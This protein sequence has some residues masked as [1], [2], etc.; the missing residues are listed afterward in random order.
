MSAFENG[1]AVFA[2]GAVFDQVESLPL[3]GGNVI[4][5]LS[6]VDE[7]AAQSMAG[8]SMGP[9]NRSQARVPSSLVKT[10]RE[11]KQDS[12]M[13]EAGQRTQAALAKQEESKE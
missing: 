3:A 8:L 10:R 4:G 2:D 6:D 5:N 9:P 7:D 11:R 13:A 12:L 1:S